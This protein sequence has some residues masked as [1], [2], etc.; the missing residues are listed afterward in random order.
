MDI[1]LVTVLT[2]AVAFFGCGH[3]EPPRQELQVETWRGERLHVTVR[4]TLDGDELALQLG[5]PQLATVP[6]AWCTREYAVEDVSD[7]RTWDQGVLG[8]VELS[9]PAD[10]AAHGDPAD[11]A[12][13][14]R[15]ERPDFTLDR[16]G[17]RLPVRVTLGKAVGDGTLVLGLLGGP[18]GEDGLVIP[19]GQGTLGGAF[20]VELPGRGELEGSFTVPCADNR[21]VTAAAAEPPRS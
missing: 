16:S 18:A 7:R 9:W 20:H 13:P 1:R 6:A 11:A 5:E 4:G 14:L 2:A 19:A 3:A 10:H 8:A 17:V 12:E 15:F 21:L